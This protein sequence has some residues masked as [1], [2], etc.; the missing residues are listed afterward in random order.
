M[1]S[2]V[3]VKQAGVGEAQGASC[4][5]GRGG[6]PNCLSQLA[7]SLARS[8]ALVGTNNCAV[9]AYTVPSPLYGV[10]IV[11]A[12][13]PEMRKPGLREVT[14]L[15][16]GHTARVWQSHDFRPQYV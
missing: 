13:L 14:E 2:L 8:L 1:P 4:W 9:M 12:H 15:A 10:G 3:T 6:D 5:P 16:F 7:V 11:C